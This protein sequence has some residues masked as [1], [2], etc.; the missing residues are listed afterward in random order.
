VVVFNVFGSPSSRDVDVVV[1]VDFDPA[2][3]P[4]RISWLHGVCKAMAREVGE[5]LGV[6]SERVNIN[7]ARVE[8][9]VIVECFKGI[10]DELNN[11][12][13]ATYSLHR[14]L[15]P[16]IVSRPVPRDV[17]L[18]VLKASRKVLTWFAKTSLR[19]AL[20]PILRS[21][22]PR[23]YA[24]GLHMIASRRDGLAAAL[25]EM[26]ADQLK[27]V[28]FQVGQT[29]LLVRG[30][31]VYTKEE[32]AEALRELKPFLFREPY[33]EVELRGLIAALEE[34]SYV[35]SK[36]LTRF[37]RI[38]ENLYAFGDAVYD[39]RMERRVGR[40]SVVGAREPAL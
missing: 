30:V 39:T 22:D 29:L 15:H 13:L 21:S 36:I 23:R 35:A 2:P 12:V 6:S 26:D 7:L 11:A 25:K 16:C 34:F 9:G 1:A 40:K 18:K 14:Q 31:E 33:T 3:R 27:G 32:V 37:V 20:L 10:P 5:A 19:R 28:A 38:G 4:E 17:P 8:S 24:E